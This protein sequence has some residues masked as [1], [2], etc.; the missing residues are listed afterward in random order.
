MAMAMAMQ[1]T[2][3]ANK[4]THTHLHCNIVTMKACKHCAQFG[5]MANTDIHKF[6]H[7]VQCAR[8]QHIHTHTNPI[9]IYPC[10]VTYGQ[11]ESLGK[12]P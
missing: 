4:H 12:N 5:A 1:C 7:S 2:V 6:S 10:H 9:H 11:S 8:E 3:T